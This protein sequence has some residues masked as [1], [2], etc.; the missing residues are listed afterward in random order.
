MDGARATVFPAPQVSPEETLEGPRPT[1]VGPG[2][3]G[4]SR[5]W[6]GGCMGPCGIPPSE[7][8]P[9]H[10]VEALF[11]QQAGALLDGGVHAIL[12][13]S[14]ADPKELT[15]AM[16]AVRE[17]HHLPILALLAAGREGTL[18]GGK[19]WEESTK[20]LREAGAEVIGVAPA[21]GPSAC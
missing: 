17:L 13:Q 12:L 21:F 20:Q 11:R 10:E 2:E 9:A 1:E 6:G 3:V 18:P 16:E 5:A 14:F 19:H 4:E 7:W 15:I 8:G